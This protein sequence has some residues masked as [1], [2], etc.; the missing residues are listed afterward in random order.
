MKEVLKIESLTKTYSGQ[1]GPNTV[2]K[3]SLI[4]I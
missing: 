1:G 4:H 2:L 3:L